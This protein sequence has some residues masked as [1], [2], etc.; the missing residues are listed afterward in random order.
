M[1][2]VSHIIDRIQQ[3]P[4]PN[5][6]LSLTYVQPLQSTGGKQALLPSPPSILVPVHMTRRRRSNAD[7]I[8]FLMT[9]LAEDS[10][11]LARATGHAEKI[12]NLLFMSTGSLQ[13]I[14]NKKKA[15]REK[16][17]SAARLCWINSI[18]RVLIQNAIKRYTV[19]IEAFEAKLKSQKLSTFSNPNTAPGSPTASKAKTL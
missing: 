6:S 15:V 5:G 4:E 10:K 11:D 9:A 16:N 7:E 19:L 1:V 13:S 8:N 18:N 12:T 17:Y 3:L 2:L 14:A